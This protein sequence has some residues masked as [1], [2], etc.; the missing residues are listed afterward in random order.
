MSTSHLFQDFG[1]LKPAKA[2]KK[3]MSIEDIEDMKLLAF[4]GGFQAGWEEALKAQSETLT[5]VSDGLAES[6]KSASFEYQ[7][8]RETLQ[9][10]VQAIMSEVVDTILPL[11]A[12]ASLG[13][14]ICELVQSLS[15]DALDRSIE[16]VLAPGREEAVQRV[17]SEELTESFKVVVDAMMSPNQICLRVGSKEMDLNLDRTVAEIATAVI[18]FFETQKTEVNDG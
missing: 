12:R 8:L 17:L 16:I 11:T 13:A 5:H 18:D 14:H 10:A 2:G 4:D 1:T 3:S 15:Q 7:E 6:L 9:T